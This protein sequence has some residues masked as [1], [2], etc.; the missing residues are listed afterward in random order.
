MIQLPPLPMEEFEKELTLIDDNYPF[1]FPD[2]AILACLG[3]GGFILLVGEA[4]LLWLFIKHQGQLSTIMKFAP[5][6]PKLLS[7]DLTVLPG[8]L[9]TPAASPT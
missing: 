9:K 7:G 5:Q 2:K 4:V 6:I 1:V 3:F 8:L